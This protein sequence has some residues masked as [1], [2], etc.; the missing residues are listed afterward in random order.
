[1]MSP[2]ASNDRKIGRLDRWAMWLSAAC[3]VHCLATTVMIAAL[4]TAGGLLGSP[5][6]HEGGLLLAV[7]LGT[8]AFARGIARHGRTLPIVLGVTGLSL[9]ASALVVAHEGGHV[10]ESM[11]TIVGVAVLAAGH[12]LNRHRHG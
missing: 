9:M 12:A 3:V 7:V 10:V 6:I 11:L 5:L 8:V 2:E 4:S 1:M